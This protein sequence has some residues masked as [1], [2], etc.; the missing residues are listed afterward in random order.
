MRLFVLWLL[1]VSVL[2]AEKGLSIEAFWLGPER[3]RTEM[4]PEFDDEMPE[5]VA[6]T[7]KPEASRFINQGDVLWDLAEHFRGAGFEVGDG[8]FVYNQ[9]TGYLVADANEVTHRALNKRFDPESVAKNVSVRF[10]VLEVDDEGAEWVDWKR[11]L[12]EENSN[13]LFVSEGKGR[14]G[15]TQAYEFKKNDLELS[16]KVQPTLAL[17]NTV[18]LWIAATLTN[19]ERAHQLNAGFSVELGEDCFVELGRAFEGRSLL[20]CFKV[21]AVLVGGPKLSLWNLGEEEDEAIKQRKKEPEFGDFEI[22][23]S[24][25]ARAIGWEVSST[26]TKDILGEP[27]PSEPEVA[28]DPFAGDFSAKEPRKKKP[29]EKLERRRELERCFPFESWQD[30]KLPL[31]YS[32]V[33]LEEEDY[34]FFGEKNSVLVVRSDN[35]EHFRLVAQVTSTLDPDPPVMLQV[36]ASVLVEKSGGVIEIV[37]KAVLPVRAGM[38]VSQTIKDASSKFEVEFQP[39]LGASDQI[40]D[41]RYAVLFGNEEGGFNFSSNTTFVSGVSQKILIRK[42]EEESLFLLLQPLKVDHAGRR[43]D[44]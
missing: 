13:V 2:Q 7:V 16:L 36:V 23:I 3:F 29:W 27:L 9:T 39:T 31:I 22:P 43:L 19:G 24:S 40:V 6:A 37:A 8:W 17:W 21:D 12:N 34:A 5:R 20:V 38:T 15:E 14:S 18:E 41:L 10:E 1:L 32:G 25:K 28:Q 42:T 35:S 30:M 33:E 26:F 4:A 11:E 44:E